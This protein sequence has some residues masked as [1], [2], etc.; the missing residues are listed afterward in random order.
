MTPG[1]DHLILDR[2]SV[3]IWTAF[4][5]IILMT[6]KVFRSV[7]QLLDNLKRLNF[8]LNF[9]LRVINGFARKFQEISPCLF[10]HWNC[11]VKKKIFR[12]QRLLGTWSSKWSRLISISVITTKPRWKD[13]TLPRLDLV[14]PLRRIWSTLF[15]PLENSLCSLIPSHL[16]VHGPILLERKGQQLLLAHVLHGSLSLKVWLRYSL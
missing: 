6:R 7:S 14:T 5:H 12:E 16:W 3:W 10:K 13:C 8:Y 2:L 9:Q 15:L 1:T 11:E 4:S